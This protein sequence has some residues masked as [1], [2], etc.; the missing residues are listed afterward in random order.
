MRYEKTIEFVRSEYGKG[1]EYADEKALAPLI[2]AAEIL[3]DFGYGLEFRVAAIL[4]NVLMDTEAKPDDVISLSSME[5]LE[6]VQIMSNHN[7]CSPEASMDAIKN[8]LL[9]HPVKLAEHLYSIRNSRNLTSV[10]KKKLLHVSEDFYLR[11][12]Q[13]TL[14]Y[15]PIFKELLNMKLEM[16]LY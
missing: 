14:F 7:G 11:C 3:E 10:E 6:A 2:G 9:A 4:M 16:E 15:E 8:N 12:A 13:G 1:M 5:V